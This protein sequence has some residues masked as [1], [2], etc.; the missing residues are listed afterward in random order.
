[1]FNK[2]RNCVYLSST[3]LSFHIILSL[4]IMSIVEEL[5]AQISTLKQENEILH[6]T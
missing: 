2:V 5:Q 6:N 1:M 3:L 4:A